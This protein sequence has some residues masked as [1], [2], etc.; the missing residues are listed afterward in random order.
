M[1]VLT[2][3]SETTHHRLASLGDLRALMLEASFQELDKDSTLVKESTISAN[4]FQR[5][6][7]RSVLSPS[8][9]DGGAGTTESSVSNSP[10]R[11]SKS[12]SVGSLRTLSRRFTLSQAEID[13]WADATPV[14]PIRPHLSRSL[15]RECCGA[16]EFVL[17]LQEPPSSRT[18]T[19]TDPVMPPTALKFSKGLAFL[20]QNKAGIVASWTWGAGF[21]IARLGPG[22]WSAPCFLQEKFLSCGLTAGFR[23]VDTCYAIPTNAGM[24]HFKVDSINSAWDLGLTLGYDPM[25]GEAPVVTAQSADR[26]SGRFAL[27]AAEKPK[28]FSISDGAILDLSWRF[29][30]H[31]VNDDLHKELYGENVTS[32]DI[33]EGKVQIPEEFK[34][35]YEMLSKLAAVGEQQSLRHTAS[36]FDAEKERNKL[37]S[38]HSLTSSLSFGGKKL[39]KNNSSTSSDTDTVG[40]TYTSQ[41]SA[42][43]VPLGSAFA[44][45]ETT[46]SPF[47]RLFGDT[48][49]L[50]L[51]LDTPE[52]GEEEN[53]EE[54]KCHC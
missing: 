28:V 5:K 8:A 37:K 29:G 23:T 22:L 2:T 12:N 7:S 25:R 6:S 53:K 48:E 33:L 51:D 30:M 3:R 10:K 17:K 14:L 43:S 38:Q 45:E 26:T 39:G 15:K 46:S 47:G 34:P 24:K 40:Y 20:Q 49:L 54:T 36:L 27:P 13:P 16:I 19:K 1:E 41:N 42:T 35:F 21:V 9:F 32:S 4:H 52:E 18:S 44:V 31:L 11:L 50:D